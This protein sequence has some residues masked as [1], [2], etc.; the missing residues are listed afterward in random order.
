MSYSLIILK[1]MLDDLDAMNS[2]T[3]I[4]HRVDDPFIRSQL[5]DNLNGIADIAKELKSKII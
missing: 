2:T 1:K 4:G 5:R 3:E